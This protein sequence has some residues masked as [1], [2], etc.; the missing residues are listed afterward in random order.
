MVVSF[1]NVSYIYSRGTIFENRALKD[2]CFDVEKG[3]FV[4]ICGRTGSGKTTLIKLING[5]IKP[6]S[7][8]VVLEAGSSGVVGLVFQFPE[9]QLFASTVIEDVM[10]GPMNLGRDNDQAR[11]DAVEALSC[12]GLGPEYYDRN[13]FAL[14][15]GQKRLA[16]LAGVLA[17]KPSVLV[18]DEPTAG[19]DFRSS[20]GLMD[21]L[22]SLNKEGVTV[23]MVT[24]EMELARDHA[25]RVLVLDRGRIALSG[26]ASEVF[27]AANRELIE[28]AGLEMPGEI[29]DFM[30]GSSL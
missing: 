16:A 25:D 5:L 4:C 20:R 6:F 3:G 15:G 10:Y 12:V 1:R 19:L 18:L 9:D 17:M 24:H 11:R 26:T 28:K 7:G 22:H 29:L 21:L 8:E 23:I 2:I 30:A 27:S 13:P 14:S